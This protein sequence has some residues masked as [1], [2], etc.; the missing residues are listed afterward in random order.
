ML[1]GVPCSKVEARS[2]QFSIVTAEGI[3]TTSANR[4]SVRLLGSGLTVAL[5]TA[6]LLSANATLAPPPP[7]VQTS[8]GVQGGIGVSDNGDKSLSSAVDVGSRDDWAGDRHK[9]YDLAA[10]ST[11]N[12][13]TMS[14]NASVTFCHSGQSK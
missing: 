9:T 6:C 5:A 14:D 12:Y 10:R 1:C 11:S 2:S 13:R 7:Y 3:M 8:A 4:S